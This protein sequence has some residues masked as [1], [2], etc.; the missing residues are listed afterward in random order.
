M[1]FPDEE[2]RKYLEA[3]F[4]LVL[5]A[6]LLVRLILF[7]IW[8]PAHGLWHLD[9]SFRMDRQCFRRRGYADW[10]D[11][12]RRAFHNFGISAALGLRGR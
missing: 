4:L 7:R 2:H 11:N 12:D 10:Y 8:S 6:R 9:R 5:S 3:N 1:A